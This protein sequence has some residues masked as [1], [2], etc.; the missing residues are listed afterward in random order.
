M[1]VTLLRL[2][3][4]EGVLG[5]LLLSMDGLPVAA[6]NLDDDDAETVS[7]LA[8][9]MLTTVRGT[10]DRLAIGDLTGASVTTQDGRIEFFLV[11]DMIL[12]VFE[13]SDL[14]RPTLEACI[15]NVIE[16]CLA[17]AL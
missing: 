11:G 15:P 2:L 4:V 8:T 13:D 6:A 3:E 7:A 1:E 5:V 17:F 9:A 12:V 16:E 14:D 10:T